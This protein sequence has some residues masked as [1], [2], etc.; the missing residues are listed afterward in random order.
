VI[1]NRC[2]V[3]APCAVNGAT[4]RCSSR[5]CARSA[6]RVF[7]NFILVVVSNLGSIVF[8]VWPF[9]VVVAGFVVFLVWN[10]GIVVGK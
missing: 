5:Q 7:I 10:G 6:R 2:V 3:F 9:V 1:R 8:L 4:H